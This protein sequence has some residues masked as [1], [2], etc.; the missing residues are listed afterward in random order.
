VIKLQKLTRN[1]SKWKWVFA[2][3]KDFLAI[4]VAE[5]SITLK[6]YL[7]L[8]GGIVMLKKMT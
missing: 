1:D 7:E 2:E 5:N 4:K 3:R 6:P 8:G